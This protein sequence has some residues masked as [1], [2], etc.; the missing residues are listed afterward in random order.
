MPNATWSIVCFAVVFG[1]DTARIDGGRD[2]VW[3]DR[4][5]SLFLESLI[6]IFPPNLQSCDEPIVMPTG[7][8]E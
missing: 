6:Q 3:L 7:A 5:K 2:G 8:E 4:N 1:E